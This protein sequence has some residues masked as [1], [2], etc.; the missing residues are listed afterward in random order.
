[1]TSF[2]LPLFPPFSYRLLSVICTDVDARADRVNASL[3]TAV[4][5]VALTVTCQLVVRSD[6]CRLR[7]ERGQGKEAI[8]DSVDS[9]CSRS[10]FTVRS[11]Q[12]LTTLTSIKQ[13]WSGN[14]SPCPLS[15]FT[16]DWLSL[17][18]THKNNDR[19]A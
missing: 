5:Y 13:L 19:K 7:K 9:L 14:S 11:P 2:L 12:Q 8:L 1:M 15:I 18:E 6:Q 17:T 16:P 10:C 4:C 3:W